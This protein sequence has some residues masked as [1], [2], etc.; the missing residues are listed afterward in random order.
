[1]EDQPAIMSLRRARKLMDHLEQTKNYVNS[2]FGCIAVR[3]N[4]RI[5]NRRF[6]SAVNSPFG[7]IASM[8]S[9]KLR[10]YWARCELRYLIWLV[11][12]GGQVGSAGSSGLMPA[13]PAEK[14]AMPRPSPIWPGVSEGCAL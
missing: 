2:R 4:H 10:Q 12:C 13:S 9:N 7:C 3:K 5:P 6:R 8:T 14:G 11:C 1:M